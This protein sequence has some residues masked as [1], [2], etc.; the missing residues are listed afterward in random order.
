LPQNDGLTQTVRSFTPDLIIAIGHEALDRVK[1]FRQQPIV[2]LLVP[3]PGHDMKNR[4][5][6]TG[7]G[8]NISPTRQLAAL[9]GK[10]PDIKRVGLV[11]DPEKTNDLVAEV[12]KG[13]QGR[14]GYHRCQGNTLTRHRDGC[15]FH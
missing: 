5:N 15:D 13:Q 4:T 12:K 2:F 10:I 6:I 3:F 14:R 1:D 8:M 7:V 11:Y 9:I